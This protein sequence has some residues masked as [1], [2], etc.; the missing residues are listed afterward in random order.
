MEPL[1]QPNDKLLKATFSQPENARAFFQ[2]HLP[3]PL[4]EII[5]WNSLSVE[6]T[7]FINPQFTSSE[8]DLL[9][10]LQ[11][12]N[13]DAFLYLLFEHQSSEDPRMAL[14]LLSY[15]VRIWERFAT[16]HPAPAKLPAVL[17]F[18]LAQGKRPWKTKPQLEPLLDLPEPLAHILRPWQ[19]SMAYQLFELVRTP[20]DQLSG[21]PEGI[22]TLRA[23]KAEPV[24]ELFTDRL[25]DEPLLGS[26]SDD[27]FERIM[28]YILNADSDVPQ[29]QERIQRLHAQTIQSKAMTLAEK[30]HQKGREEGLQ[31][32]MTL[33]EKLHQKGREEGLREATTLAK[34]FHQKGREEGLREATTLAKTFHQKGREEGVKAGQLNALRS[35][36]IRAVEIRHG[37]CPEG[38]RETIESLS[39][40]NRLE[41]LLESAF[42]S[43]SV[44][45]FSRKL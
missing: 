2:H 12:Q 6:S 31:E 28:R 3:P 38:L 8:S 10:H 30:I 19:P 5:D 26:L 35:A 34:T 7:S 45:E 23:L 22:L 9:F 33:A 36:V 20:Y 37:L 1:H 40:F 25:W 44:E 27:A 24:G 39:D 16:T 41:A 42:R 18:V 21:T 17:P 29:F 15:V 32:G 43:N 11:L 4:T 13:S 14:R